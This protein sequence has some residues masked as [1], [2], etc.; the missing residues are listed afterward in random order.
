[1]TL[2]FSVSQGA[3]ALVADIAFINN[4]NPTVTNILW[5]NTSLGVTQNVAA[6]RRIEGGYGQFHADVHCLYDPLPGVGY[7]TGTIPAG[8]GTASDLLLQAY[9]V[10]GVDTS[11]APVGYGIGTQV[12]TPYY[13][14]YLAVTLSSST[15]VN[16][17]AG[18]C[19]IDNAGDLWPS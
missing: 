10:A 18:M 11:I 5:V 9:T 4:N 16:S 8:G 1:M 2:P 12:I 3:S 17:W 7:L 13:T 6:G 19:T 15:P 14:N